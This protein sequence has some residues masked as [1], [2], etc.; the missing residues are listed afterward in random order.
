MFVLIKNVQLIGLISGESWFNL[1]I[2]E[3]TNKCIMLQY[4]FLNSSTRS[5]KKNNFVL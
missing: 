1:K 3:N 4:K 2:Q 5:K